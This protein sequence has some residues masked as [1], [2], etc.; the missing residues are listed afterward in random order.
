MLGQIF[1]SFVLYNRSNLAGLHLFKTDTLISVMDKLL[2]IVLCAPFI[3]ISDLRSYLSIPFFVIIQ[4]LSFLITAIASF[5]FVRKHTINLEWKFDKKASFDIIKKSLPFTILAGLMFIYTKADTII[6]KELF[7]NG[8]EEVGIYAAAYRLI[9]ALNM[10]AVL[11]AGLLYP[12]FSRMIQH[13]DNIEPLVKTAFSLLVIP[14]C[15]GATL[16]FLY[17]NQVMELLYYEHTNESAM[18][19]S[20]LGISFIGICNTYVFG[21]LLTANGNISLLNKIALLGVIINLSLNLYFTPKYGVISAAII[22]SITFTTVSLF[23]TYYSFKKFKFRLQYSYILRS[24]VS[25][26]SIFM[27]I[28]L[29]L[30]SEFTW[31]YQAVIIGLL[32]IIILI[33]TRLIPIKE[34]IKVLKTE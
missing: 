15:L 1:N 31:I 16:F 22:S 4:C 26:I 23:H 21:T 14:A 33:I 3:Y 2:M 10:I 17:S 28:Y 6:I 18:V 7:Y 34:M 32:S 12:M 20:I 29:N 9:D 11:F 13:N 19:F 25:A 27:L 8:N 24:T 5:L 30:G